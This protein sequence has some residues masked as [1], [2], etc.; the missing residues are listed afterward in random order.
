[1]ANLSKLKRLGV[2]PSPEEVTTNLKS[3]EIAPSNKYYD[4]EKFYVRKDARSMMKTNRILTFATRVSPQFDREFR[5]IAEREN[6]R[7][8]V[9]LE[10]MLDVYKEKKGYE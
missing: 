5:E 7:L 6:V 4:N 1:M 10:L 2:P 8:T 9:L 3:P